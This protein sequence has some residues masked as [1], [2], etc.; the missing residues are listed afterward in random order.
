MKQNLS[1]ILL[2]FIIFFGF[3]FS[4]SCQNLQINPNKSKSNKISGDEISQL[5]LNKVV[6]FPAIVV[7]EFNS[8]CIYIYT[9]DKFN[10]YNGDSKWAVSA[11]FENNETPFFML[12]WTK[13]GTVTGK[14]IFLKDVTD[15]DKTC[16]I[17]TGNIFEISKIEE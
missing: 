2:T 10:K 9:E 11:R 13:K 5:E 8:N 14:M 6:S 3:L 17:V 12:F 7:K 1:N 15:T 4:I 16:D